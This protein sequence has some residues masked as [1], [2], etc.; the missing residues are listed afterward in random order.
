[1]PSQSW[2]QLDPLHVASGQSSSLVFVQAYSHP[3]SG[4]VSRFTN[5]VRHGPSL[6]WL[7]SHAGSDPGRLHAL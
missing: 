4:A 3:F 1:M 2:S 6:H 7:F 5:P